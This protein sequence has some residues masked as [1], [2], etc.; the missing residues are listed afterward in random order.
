MRSCVP[1]NID[2][3]TDASP[4][5]KWNRAEGKLNLKLLL[6]IPMLYA[7][8][9][10]AIQ[11]CCKRPINAYKDVD[12]IS[13]ECRT[14]VRCTEAPIYAYNARS[15]EKV[16]TFLNSAVKISTT[17][18]IGNTT[19]FYLDNLEEIDHNGTGPALTLLNAELGLHSFIKLNIIKV[20]DYSVFCN[21]GAELIRI[22]GYIPQVVLDRLYKVGNDT[23][24]PCKSWKATTQASV[25]GATQGAGVPSS[26]S[27]A[28]ISRMCT[29]K[30][31][32]EEEKCSSNNTLLYI[33]CGVIV[34]LLIVS[35][36]ST[37]IALKFYFW[38]H[39]KDLILAS[40]GKPQ[41]A[42]P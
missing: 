15:G 21:G 26:N 41:T 7:L 25:L 17:V 9:T 11:T 24:K 34:V 39:K 31:D 3:S 38:R 40:L 33:A 5:M 1:S 37:I 29:Q 16:Y 12:A 4:R 8:P 19:S 42:T 32:A 36:V 13:V 23:L 14:D 18:I 10:T 2:Q 6:M 35:V 28:V 30:T 20:P 27:S 22:E